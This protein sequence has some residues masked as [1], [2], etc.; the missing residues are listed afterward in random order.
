MP[1]AQDYDAFVQD[2]VTDD[3]VAGEPIADFVR[4]FQFRRDGNPFAHARKATQAANAVK[5][6]AGDV[7]GGSRIFLRNKVVQPLQVTQGLR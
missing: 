5:Q 3:V 2:E 7:A 6:F 1:D 4:R